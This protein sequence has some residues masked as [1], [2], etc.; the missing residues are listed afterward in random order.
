MPDDADNLADG[1]VA[2]PP[3]T[4]RRPEPQRLRR[5][6]SGAYRPDGLVGPTRR[7]IL[8]VALLVALASLPTLAAITAG[9]HTL[10]GASEGPPTVPF[11]PPPSGGPVIVPRP[12]TSPTDPAPPVRAAEPVAVAPRPPGEPP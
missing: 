11:L 9:S 2:A 12:T 3:P 4:G 8:V 7:Y 1:G 10:D 5:D 6:L